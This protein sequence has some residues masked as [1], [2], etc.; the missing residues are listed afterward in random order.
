MLTRPQKGDEFVER[1][2]QTEESGQTPSVIDDVR[3]S[4]DLLETFIILY[5]VQ[6]P[7]F[8]CHD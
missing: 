3:F 5:E 2:A 4:I 1:S 8:G 6:T 7:W